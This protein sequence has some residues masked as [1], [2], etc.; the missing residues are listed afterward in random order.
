MKQAIMYCLEKGLYSAIDCREV[1]A[2]LQADATGG[3]PPV[4]KVK[5]PKQ[6]RLQTEHRSLAAYTALVGGENDE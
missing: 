3:M 2:M 6:F 1:V 5:L 4:D